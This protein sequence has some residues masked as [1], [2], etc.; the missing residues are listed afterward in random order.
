MQPWLI[1]SADQFLPPPAID[2]TEYATAYEEA[3]TLGGADSETLGLRT[4]DQTQIALFW[5]DGAGTFTPPGH[6][7][8]IASEAASSAGRTTA[9][10][11]A[12]MARLN[13]ALADAAITCWN[14]KYTFDYW[15]PVTAINLGTTDGNVST[16]GDAAWTPLISTP[17]FP[18]YTSGHS[19][20]SG[21]TAT[22]LTAEFGDNYAFTTGTP[23]TMPD[24]IGVTRSFTSFWDA[25]REAGQS[26]IYGG[27]HFQPANQEG[28]LCGQ[29]VGNWVLSQFGA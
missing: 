12:L 14:A 21:A 10:I 26:R 27:I 23:S 1:Q 13:I 2:S 11:A 19:T 6:W 7:N 28:L 16:T 17:P 4:A 5:A 18:E 20:F 15:R 22:V 9:E 25:A 8:Q 3:R 29:Q 24:L